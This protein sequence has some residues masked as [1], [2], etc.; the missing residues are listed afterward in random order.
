[1]NTEL[2]TQYIRPTH[3]PNGQYL[4]LLGLI[5]ILLTAILSFSL[6]GIAPAAIILLLIS[7]SMLALIGYAS[8]QD[9]ALS[10]TLTFMHIQFHSPNGGWTTRWTNIE[11]I[12]QATIEQDGWH[13]PIPWV[14]IK[15]KD[16]EGFIEDICPRVASKL[17]IEQRPLLV[18]AHKRSSNTNEQLEDI[19][20]DDNRTTLASGKTFK[21]LQ[22]MLANRMRYNRAYL[23]YDFFI[24]EDVLDRPAAD[25]AGLARRYLAAL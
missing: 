9:A 17:L 5:G 14:G 16:Y 3:I 11:Q 8:Y 4:C 19:L 25:F 10:F 21:G 7:A 12:A 23:G 13:Q 24:S 20:F 2:K 22:A 15:L 1:M 18:M 6:P